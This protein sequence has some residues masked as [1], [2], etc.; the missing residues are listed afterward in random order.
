V[1]VI[2]EIQKKEIEIDPK[3][4]KIDTFRASGAGGQHVNTTDSAVRVTHIP[5]GITVSSQNERS[6]F[7]NKDT[8]MKIL[9]SKLVQYN[10]EKSEEEKAKLRGEISPASWGNQIRSYVLHPYNLVKDHRT[11]L[12]TSNTKAV[13]D[14][15]IEQ[16]I[17]AYLRKKEK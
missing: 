5:T 17:E 3:D 7:Q 14:G 15:D 8:A 9:E 16:F 13:L 12:E 2:P 6:Q 11:N 1:D 10:Q 4:L